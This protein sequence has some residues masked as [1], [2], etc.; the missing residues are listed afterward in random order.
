MS[1]GYMGKLLRV[2]LTEGTI[3]SEELRPDWVRKFIGGAGL[4]TRYLYEEVPTGADP[5]GPENLLIFMAG[6]THRNRIGKR[7]PLFG[8]SKIPLN[9][10]MGSGEFRW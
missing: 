4:A 2:N 5:L 7:Q 1:R 8:R 3:S 6:P 9:R 10:N